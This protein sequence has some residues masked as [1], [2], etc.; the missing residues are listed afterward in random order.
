[1]EDPEVQAT[2]KRAE[3]EF[4]GG[5]ATGLFARIP[6]GGGPPPVLQTGAREAEE[7]AGGRRR[8]GP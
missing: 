1:M 8:P 5:L 7:Q 6:S 3:A 4:L 2:H